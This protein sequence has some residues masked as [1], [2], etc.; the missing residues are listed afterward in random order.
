MRQYAYNKL[1]VIEKEITILD[2]GTSGV[3]V[4]RI[5]EGARV[6]NVNVTVDEAYD[7]TTA[8]KVD[9][10]VTGDLTKFQNQLSLAAVGGANSVRQ[11]TAAETTTDV[12]MSVT[13]TVAAAGKA[14]VSVL[15]RNASKY[16]IG[17]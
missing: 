5:P 9:L 4:A 17:Q 15:Y 14:T 11:H 7:G 2:V 3:V 10:G 16:V 13:G 8:N 12:L 6:V 1:G